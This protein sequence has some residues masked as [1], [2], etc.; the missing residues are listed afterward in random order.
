MPDLVSEGRRLA[1]NN[2]EQRR[3]NSNSDAQRRRIESIIRQYQ[4]RGYNVELIPTGSNSDIYK[5]RVSENYGYQ[6][7]SFQNNSNSIFNRSSSQNNSSG[8][9]NQNYNRQVTTLGTIQTHRIV[10]HIALQIEVHTTHQ[11]AVHM[12]RL[13]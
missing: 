12:V 8:K 2:S 4:S 9:T 11:G 5:L 3:V 10:D 6:G 13:Q 1:N 7:R